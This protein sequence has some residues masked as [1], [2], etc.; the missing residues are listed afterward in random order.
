MNSSV[1]KGFEKS[2]F[3]VQC[4]TLYLK[5]ERI[6]AHTIG[7]IFSALKIIIQVHFQALDI[8]FYRL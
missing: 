2:H 1:T 8:D 6:S 4:N 3:T 7:A 5:M